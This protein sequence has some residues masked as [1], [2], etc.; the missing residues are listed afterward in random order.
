MGERL[1][2][3]LAD[4]VR[5]V[6]ARLAETRALGFDPADP[7]PP[8]DQVVEAD[9][10]RRDVAPRL[11]RREDDPVAC[12]K[13]VD[14]LGLD[15]RQLAVGPRIGRVSANLGGVAVALEADS[16]ERPHPIDRTHRTAARGGE[17][18]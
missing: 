9:P 14:L 16:G 5:E 15:E 2:D 17:V 13:G 3:R 10:P 11:A 7:E 12:R 8:S 1:Q 18:D 6:L 4:R